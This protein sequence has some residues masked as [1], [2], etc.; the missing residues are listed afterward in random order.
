[1]A[2]QPREF[3]PDEA[4]FSELVLYVSEKLAGDPKF[5]ATKLNNILFAADLFAYGVLG[6][7]ITGVEYVRRQFGP[8]PKLFTAYRERM[9][10]AG[11]L[12]FEER[13]YMGKT[14]KRPI[15]RRSSNLDLFTARQIALV[16][17]VMEIFSVA[18]AT[19]LSEWSHG[20]CGWAVAR[21][22]ATIPYEAVF[23]SDRAMTSYE[24]E[25]GRQ[26]ALE[27]GW[28]VF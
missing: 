26:L 9:E 27:R 21:P 17:Q 14:Q 8:A 15:A 6:S 24:A 16:D 28:D 11:A 19:Q 3:T 13:P 23:I 4:K 22:D 5:G 1:M 2:T 7:P 12:E 10:Q 25:H 20:L 18:N